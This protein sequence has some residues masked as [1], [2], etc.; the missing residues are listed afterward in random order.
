[1]DHLGTGGQLF[2]FVTKVLTLDKMGLAAPS[3]PMMK[4]L[5][6]EEANVLLGVVEAEYNVEIVMEHTTGPAL[7]VDIALEF[8]TRIV[9]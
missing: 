7:E 4:S 8:C 5:S 6:A 3:L 2:L 9:M 1:M